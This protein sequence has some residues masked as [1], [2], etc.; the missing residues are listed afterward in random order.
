MS[1]NLTGKI[2]GENTLSGKL[3]TQIKDVTEIMQ[4][5]SIY[6]FPNRGVVSTL[7]ITSDENAA[8]RWDLSNNRY[9]CIGRNYQEIEEINGGEING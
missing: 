5:G 9:Y 8:Y 2:S 1:A 4:Y 6:E 3:S 7:Y